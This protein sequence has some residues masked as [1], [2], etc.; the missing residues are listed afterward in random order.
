MLP[1]RIRRLFRKPESVHEAEFNGQTYQMRGKGTEEEFRAWFFEYA[2][3]AP[4]C[5][6]CGRIFFPNQPYG[7]NGQELMHMNT[8][9]CDTGGFHAGY[10]SEEGE[11]EPL[12]DHGE[13]VAM[14]AVKTRQVI[15]G[16]IIHPEDK[17]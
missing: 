8:D 12:Y 2:P 7:K 11:L 17:K 10:I 1:E 3:K 4:V 14:H 16:N 6:S 9:C 13:S 15:S 5:T